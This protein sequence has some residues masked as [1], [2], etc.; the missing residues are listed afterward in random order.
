MDLIYFSPVPWNSIAQRPHFFIKQA[1]IFGFKNIIWVNPTPSRF[2]QLSDFRRLVSPFEAKSFEV[3]CNIKI[4]NPR[5]I[6]IEPMHFIYKKINNGNM[7]N[8]IHEI[9]SHMASKTCHIVIGKPSLLAIYLLD[10]IEYKSSTLDIMDNFPCFFTGMAKQSVT[11][12]LN[13]LISRVD[14]SLY[15][16]STLKEIYNLLDERSLLILNACDSAFFEKARYH[17]R[18]ETTSKKLIFGYVGTIASWFDW[19]A[20]YGLAKDYPE[21]E[22][23]IIGPN[24]SSVPNGLPENIKLFP[25]VE[26]SSIGGVISDFDYGIIPFKV[27][28]LTDSVDPVKYYEY[29]AYDLPV[30]STRFGQMACRID[31]Q[32]VYDFKTFS[33]GKTIKSENTITWSERF[34]PFFSYLSL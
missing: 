18:L 31:S 14:I 33:I 8:I 34:A 1:V 13:Y 22:V 9:K 20:V 24:Y 10:N 32:N 21:S 5:L 6:P 19:E 11:K 16:C 25:A 28:E 23:R 4:I 7:N 2:P 15:S 30:I 27:N 17:Q 3:P 29:R 26:H 12:I